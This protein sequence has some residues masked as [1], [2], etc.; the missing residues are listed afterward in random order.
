MCLLRRLRSL[1]VE[2]RRIFGDVKELVDMDVF[3]NVYRPLLDATPAFYP[4]GLELRGVAP[5]ECG[6]WEIQSISGAGGR[7][8]GGG[9]GSPSKSAV[10]QAKGPSAGQSTMVVLFDLLLGVKHV[11]GNAGKGS[12]EFQ[13]EMLRYMPPKHAQMCRDMRARIRQSGSILS[14]IH[15]TRSNMDQRYNSDDESDELVTAFND[16]IS[17]SLLEVLWGGE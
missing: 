1:Y 5:G 8:G 11:F 7:R 10:V 9:D 6:K 2:F 4:L 12:G 14:Y 13:E 3:Y 15:R 17:V 16:L